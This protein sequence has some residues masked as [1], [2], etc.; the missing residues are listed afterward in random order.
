MPKPAMRR[1]PSNGEQ[2]AHKRW[3]KKNNF[4]LQGFQPG[5]N[6][7]PRN[8]NPTAFLCTF[9]VVCLHGL[10]SKGGGVCGNPGC[11]ALGGRCGRVFTGSQPPCLTNTPPSVTRTK[12]VSISEPRTIKAPTATAS[13]AHRTP[14]P[15]FPNAAAPAG[16]A[17]DYPCQ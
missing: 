10:S 1:K 17:D 3:T 9:G 4:C 2:P 8:Q 5:F 12:R 14:R 11:T 7:A 16:L 6:V 13:P 15:A